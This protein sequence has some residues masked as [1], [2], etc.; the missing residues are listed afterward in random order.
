VLEITPPLGI[1]AAELEAGLD[2]ILR[3]ADDAVAGG[4]PRSILTEF[5]GW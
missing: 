3:A 2:V 1:T 4:V 5:G